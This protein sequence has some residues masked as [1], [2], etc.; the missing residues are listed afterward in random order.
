MINEQRMAPVLTVK[1]GNPI[2]VDGELSLDSI[3]P[4]QNKVITSALMD[5]EA[6]IT[7][8]QEIKQDKENYFTYVD[9]DE[10][11][12]EEPEVPVSIDF[13]PEGVECI[14]D[15]RKLTVI[16]DIACKVGY[17]NGGLYDPV[18]AI[19]DS[20]GNHYFNIPTEMR[21]SDGEIAKVEHVVV[22]IKGD[23]DLNNEL[24]YADADLVADYVHGV[25]TAA[26]STLGYFAA[27][28]NNNDRLTTSESTRITNAVA[29]LQPLPWNEEI[30]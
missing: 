9:V 10:I 26:L 27:N 17:L 5:I 1:N 29:G 12:N 14:L 4:V 20:E 19:E 13:I 21:T 30:R 7:E 22:V 28:L 3:N 2:Q 15:G 8:L 24:E 25:P 23:A 16:S 18:E 6:D 11:W